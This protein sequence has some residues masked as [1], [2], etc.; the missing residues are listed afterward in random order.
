MEKP[1]PLEFALT[2]LHAQSAMLSALSKTHPR[3]EALRAQ[4]EKE[5]A[6]R[7]VQ[8]SLEASPA[9]VEML[10][11]MLADFGREIPKTDVQH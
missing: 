6:H 4:F 3:P 7:I 8:C 9:V 1:S 10:R 11:G 5:G 2:Y